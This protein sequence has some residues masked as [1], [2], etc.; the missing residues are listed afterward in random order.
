MPH[1]FAFDALR[2]GAVSSSSSVKGS[3]AKKLRRKVVSQY[4][5]VSEG[6]WAS[7]WPAATKNLTVTKLAD[8]TSIYHL[9]GT[10]LF[11]TNGGKG[12]AGSWLHPTL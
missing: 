7:L 3:D 9:D 2:M 6:Q 11:Y 8:K 1:T 12:S 10:P 5:L 4:P